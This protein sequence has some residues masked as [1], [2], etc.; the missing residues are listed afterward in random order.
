M[1]AQFSASVANIRVPSSP[2]YRRLPIASVF[3]PSTSTTL[4]D[5]VRYL[6]TNQSGTLNLS[7][8]GTQRLNLNDVVTATGTTSDPYAVATNDAIQMQIY[9][10]VEALKFH[11]PYFGQRFYRL[12]TDAKSTTLNDATQ[13]PGSPKTN[14]ATPSGQTDASE[15][16]YYKVAANLRDY[17]DN[18]L[19]PTVIDEG[20]TV[21]PHGQAGCRS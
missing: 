1:L 19:Q 7:R 2:I 13:V 20:G 5:A 11:L 21:H 10:I 14:P 16:Y 8:H 15:I 9:Q 12:S 4:V 3:T 17:I 18:D 6:T